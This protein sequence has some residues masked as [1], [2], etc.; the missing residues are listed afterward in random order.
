MTTIAYI[1]KMYITTY[2]KFRKHLIVE[3][4]ARR[5]EIKDEHFLNI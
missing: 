2:N 1:F 4:N 5:A 3:K